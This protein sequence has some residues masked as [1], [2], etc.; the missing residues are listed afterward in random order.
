[1]TKTYEL[2]FLGRS[3][4]NFVLVF[5]K[6]IF[7]MIFSLIFAFSTLA[8][9]PADG[10]LFENRFV[11]SK[12]RQGGDWVGNGAGLGENSF[13]FAYGNLDR[14]ISLCFESSVCQLSKTQKAI[15]QKISDALPLER[16]NTQQLGFTDDQSYF[17]SGKGGNTFHRV[18]VTQAFVGAKI[19]VNNRLLLAQEQ[20]G[21]ELR[22][23][24]VPQAVGILIHE[25]GHHHGITSH[26][27]LDTLGAQ[28]A[29]VLD[30]S[31]QIDYL[32]ENQ[33]HVVAM[34]LSPAKEVAE[35]PRILLTDG[36][37]FIDLTTQ[38]VNQIQCPIKDGQ[39][40]SLR[41]VRFRSPRFKPWDNGALDLRLEILC[42]SILGGFWYSHLLAELRPVYFIKDQKY[43][44][45]RDQIKVS[46]LDCRDQRCG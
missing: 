17:N 42:R 39:I 11:L 19:W 8:Q 34:V 33:S 13:R 5:C 44:F 31:I 16:R 29:R 46:I 23:I 32:Q 45:V 18:A 24:S 9:A 6:K 37:E 30:P 2:L 36:S 41:G 25:M 10:F 3:K 20:T 4:F 26:E 35:L 1:M 27:D 22:A 43:F 40:Q 12:E 7:F 38:V 21:E 14:Y 15:L 28:V